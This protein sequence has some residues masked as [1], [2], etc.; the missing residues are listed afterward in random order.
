MN[1]KVYAVVNEKG[2][3]AKT[4]TSTALAYL[5]VQQGKKTL[6]V[7]MDGQAHATL[8]YGVEN[9]NLLETTIATLLGKVILDEPLPAPDSYLIHSHGVDLVPANSQLFVLERNLCNV[10]FRERVLKSYLDTIKEGYDYVII[11]TMP[12][13]GTAMMNVLMCADSVIIPT[14]AEL[15]SAVGLTE[16]IRHCSAIKRNTGHDL[17]IEGILITMYDRR[18]KLSKEVSEML[19]DSCG[20]KV[21]LF[22]TT[23]PRS[24]KVGEAALYGKTI[25]EYQPYS[26]VTLAYQ[27]LIKE[28]THD[29]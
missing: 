12:Q 23:I 28:L 26:P 29:E 13:M 24:V 6:L 16:L 27:G 2:G 5:L 19:R 21:R 8:L 7:D 18:T 11:D 25:C 20:S 1:T 9:A 14:Q 22:H 3:V 4:V 10:D 15:L 17:K